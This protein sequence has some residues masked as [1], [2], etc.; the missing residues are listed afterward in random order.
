MTEEQ[1]R[2][3]LQDFDTYK[4]QVQTWKQCLAYDKNHSEMPAKIMRQLLR[5]EILEK[6][7]EI[8]ESQ[9][10]LVIKTHL[11]LKNTWD[12]TYAVCED[13]WGSENGRSLRTLK[14][15]QS[16]GLQRM[17]AFIIHSDLE[18]YFLSSSPDTLL[19]CNPS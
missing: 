8:L 16:R 10:Q 14:R 4:I 11:I 19:N 9:E 12:V 6:A 2:Q 17:L 15:M 18:K 3:Y 13:A 7:L 1:L 5:I